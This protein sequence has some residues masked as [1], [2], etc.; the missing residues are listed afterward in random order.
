MK[1]YRKEITFNL[2]NKQEFVNIT[3]AVQSVVRESGIN[4]GFVFC[5][6]M[7][8]TTSVF[9]NTDD[10]ALHEDYKDWIDS[11]MPKKTRSGY[12]HKGYGNNAISHLKREILGRGAL[13]SITNGN[14]ELGDW[15]QIIYAEFDGMRE[16]RIVIKIIGE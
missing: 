7:H 6:T 10:S 4:D 3:A 2:P 14:I 15:E 11:L 9:V 8:G 13:I 16:K 12:I 5:N 1:S